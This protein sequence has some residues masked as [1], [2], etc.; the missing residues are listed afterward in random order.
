MIS[1]SLTCE[2]LKSSSESILA[3]VVVRGVAGRTERVVSGVTFFRGPS[4]VLKLSTVSEALRLRAVGG[5][6]KYCKPRLA[7]YDETRLQVR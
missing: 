5:V 7:V 1:S 3:D 6:M 2:L 4:S